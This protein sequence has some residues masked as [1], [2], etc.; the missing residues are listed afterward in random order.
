MDVHTLMLCVLQFQQMYS[1]P[2]VI[3]VCTPPYFHI[4][5]SEYT[6]LHVMKVPTFVLFTQAFQV[7]YN[8]FFFGGG[9][10]FWKK[11]AIFW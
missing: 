6:C 1:N 8:F 10:D 9:G 2:Y 11:P 7:L 3:C 5:M 4:D